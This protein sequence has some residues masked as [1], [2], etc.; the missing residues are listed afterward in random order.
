M[1]TKNALGSITLA[2]IGLA[3]CGNGSE[4]GFAELGSG[5]SGAGDA[6]TMTTPHDA[7]G[8]GHDAG[9]TGGKDASH[10]GG[11]AGHDSGPTHDASHGADTGHDAGTGHDSGGGAHDA[12]PPEDGGHAGVAI[13]YGES[14]G[15]LYSLDPTTKAVTVV[16]AFANC[17]TSGVIDIALDKSSKMY[18][19]TF[20]GVYTVDTSNAVCTLIA[21]GATYPNSLS[22]VPAGTLDPNTEAL[23][24][25]Q[26]ANY[27]RIDTM[28]GA[29]TTVGPAALGPT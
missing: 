27:V 21:S 26:G 2:L 22:F 23:V 13:V 29:I 3:A 20:Q 17:D 15:T 1:Q 4:G 9:I 6:G 19:T 11:Q 7:G 14:A 24:G 10:D 5:D 16:G 8:A 12:R 18:A 28:T 25:Y